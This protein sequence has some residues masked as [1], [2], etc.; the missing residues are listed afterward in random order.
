MPAPGTP[1]STSP[2]HLS[3]P[4]KTCSL[5]FQNQDP[6]PP[7]TA[8]PSLWPLKDAAGNVSYLPGR[9]WLT[10]LCGQDTVLGHARSSH[11]QLGRGNAGFQRLGALSVWL[12]AWG[13]QSCLWT[14]V[15]EGAQPQISSAPSHLALGGCPTAEQLAS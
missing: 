14:K 1:A 11:R 15:R 9:E 3:L 8:R 2:H 7:N 10:G 13:E 6:M 4:W 12:W 5:G